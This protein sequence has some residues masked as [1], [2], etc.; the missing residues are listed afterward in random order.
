MTAVELS[1]GL[2][3]TTMVMGAISSLWYAMGTTW[4][5]SGAAQGA[6]LTASIASARIE[7]R[8]R[9]SRYF[10]QFAAG[11][12]TTTPATPAS[13]FYWKDDNW[14]ASPDGIVQIAEMALIE[15][16]PV[17]KKIYVYEAMPAASMSAAQLTRAGTNATAAD[18]TASTSPAAF[19][20]L[21]FVKQAILTDAVTYASFNVPTA[22]FG[23]RPVIEYTLKVSRPEGVS[24]Q[25]GSASPRATANPG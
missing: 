24:T 18:M 17:T 8:I 1:I 7:A 19:K 21:D 4:K 9:A 3:I 23:A 5:I 12:L 11:S 25:Y 2:V 22:T 20:K 14:T 10:F 15:H 6:G 16:D 13:L